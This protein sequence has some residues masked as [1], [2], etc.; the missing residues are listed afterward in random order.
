VRFFFPLRLLERREG[1]AVGGQHSTK[2]EECYEWRRTRMQ[3]D[4]DVKREEESRE[5]NPKNRTDPSLFLPHST[6]NGVVL[7]YAEPPEARK[8]VKSWRLYV[9]KGKEQ[10]GAWLTQP[11]SSRLF[12]VIEGETDFGLRRLLH[13]ELFHVHRQSAYLFG[14]DR[15]V[16]FFSF[17]LFPPFFPSLPIRLPLTLSLLCRSILTLRPTLTGR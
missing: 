6:L 16:R 15:I 8:P 7:K 2:S 9:F 11:S 14:R 17:S 3:P 12:P 13:A 1:F 4:G 5:E 10:V